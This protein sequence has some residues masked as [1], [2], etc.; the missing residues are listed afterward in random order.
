MTAGREKIDLSMMTPLLEE[1]LEKAY[2]G[3]ERFRPA[4]PPKSSA[5]V[6]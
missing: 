4:R 3:A 2:G 5:T 6:I 1:I